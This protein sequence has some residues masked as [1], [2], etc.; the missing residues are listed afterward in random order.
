M[1]IYAIFESIH[2]LLKT[3]KAIR[4]AEL[5]FELRPNPAELKS[6][7]GMCIAFGE[8]DLDSIKNIISS[9]LEENLYS[10]YRKTKSGF[11]SLK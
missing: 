7:C 8:K 5:K 6:S 4:K 9:S 1:N 3:E 10:L 2:F 11:R